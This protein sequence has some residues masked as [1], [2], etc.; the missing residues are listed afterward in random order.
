M[1]NGFQI[2]DYVHVDDVVDALVCA[3]LRLQSGE[4]RGALSYAIPSGRQLTVRELVQIVET[5]AG[6]PINAQWGELPYK[7]REIMKPVSAGPPLPGWT[8][9]VALESGIAGV[10]RGLNPT[11]GEDAAKRRAKSPPL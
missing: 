1:S 5:V 7:D 10:L 11:V 3:D 8:P 4:S 2:V 6:R 9:K